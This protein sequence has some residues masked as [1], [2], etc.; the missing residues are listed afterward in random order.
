MEM[1]IAI[2]DD[3]KQYMLDLK[4]K[5]IAL[6]FAIDIDLDIAMYESSEALI[7]RIDNENID[8]CFLD[9][10][11]PGVN[12]IDIAQCLRNKYKRDISIVFVS[13]YP[14][15]MCDSFRVH[16]YQF[17]QKPV[18][19]EE[20]KKLMMDIKEDIISENTF[21]TILSGSN[22]EY[23]I[24]VKEICFIEVGSSRLKE[25]RFHLVDQVVE[26]RGVLMDWATELL[27]KGFVM[28][29]RSAIVNIAQIH[30]LDNN[31]I[32]CKN[33]ETIHVSKRNRSLLMKKYLQNVTRIRGK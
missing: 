10:E 26:T 29:S 28:V 24:D 19:N 7:E 15:Y 21:I 32:V 22:K 25:L 2:C 23:V 27:D 14:E 18:N 11:M 4:E 17:L 20:L 5:L 16:P 30:Y 12:G 31:E 9:I 33:S 6:S 3:E 8:V 13:N 1:K